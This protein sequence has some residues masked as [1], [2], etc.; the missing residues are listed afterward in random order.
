MI[1][2]AGQMSEECAR[3]IWIILAIGAD[4][5]VGVLVWFYIIDPLKERAEEKKARRKDM[6]KTLLTLYKE[7]G[8]DPVVKTIENELWA[9]QRAVGGNIEVVNYRDGIVMIID[10]EGYMR[11]KR[12]NIFGISGPIVVCRVEGE[13][14]ASLKDE[15]IL[16]LARKDFAE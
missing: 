8:K 14:F 4:S 7:P 11:F 3:V 13:D 2:P 15:E 10:E 16:D 6:A 9:L 5:I 12:G 1:I